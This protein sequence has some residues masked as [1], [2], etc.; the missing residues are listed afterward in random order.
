[1]ARRILR[2]D[3]PRGAQRA[4]RGREVA[5]LSEQVPEAQQHACGNAVAGRRR[6]I[7][8]HLAAVDQG[9]VIIRGEIETAGRVVGKALQHDIEELSCEAQLIG[10]EAH[11]LQ[12][13]DRVGE[14]HV[15]VQVRIQM[16]A[17][18]HGGCQQ[19]AIPPQGGADEIE[20][21]R[22]GCR[23]LLAGQGPRRYR[24]AADHERVPRGEDLVIAR[25]THA[26]RAHREQLRARRCD[27]RGDFRGSAVHLTG[28]LL[29]GGGHVEMPVALEVGRPVES[30]ARCED[31]KLRSGERG[32][33]LLAIPDVELAL[34]AFGVGVEAR[35]VAALR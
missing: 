19:P 8:E 12:L 1:M 23:Q 21:A 33:H 7:A 2:H 20:G 28:D 5:R 27:E 15:V 18:L 10:A 17:A 25:R 3:R 13:E 32:T 4:L 24:H 14:V 22:R 11:L 6:I 16:G 30:E 34:V 9:L 31:G 26:R 29:R 35:V